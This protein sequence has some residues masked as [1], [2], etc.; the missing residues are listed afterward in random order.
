MFIPMFQRTCCLKHPRMGTVQSSRMLIPIYQIMHCHIQ[1]DSNPYIKPVSFVEF[2]IVFLKLVTNLRVT[3]RTAFSCSLLISLL[4]LESFIIR[5][6]LI[7]LQYNM[8]LFLMTGE[9][10]SKN[11]QE[12]AKP[13]LEPLFDS[14]LVLL[15]QL[16]TDVLSHH[17]LCPNFYRCF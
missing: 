7:Y 5:K 13:M 3:M 4:S 1:E 17:H 15:S 14:S 2:P 12:N 9:R 6:K 8:I 16:L 10:E 11:S